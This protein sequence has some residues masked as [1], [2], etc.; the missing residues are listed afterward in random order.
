M[1]DGKKIMYGII[2]GNGDRKRLLRRLTY[3]CKDNIK[4]NIR[5]SSKVKCIDLGLR[6]VQ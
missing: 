4:R 3:S 5:E 2:I 1:T 6:R